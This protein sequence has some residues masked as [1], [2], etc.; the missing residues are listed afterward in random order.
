MTEDLE[1]CLEE[2]KKKRNH[3]K[4]FCHQQNFSPTS[5]M[6][7]DSDI[8]KFQPWKTVSSIVIQPNLKELGS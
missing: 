8:L 3:I 2:V 7:Y 5:Y 1:F 4:I 6:K